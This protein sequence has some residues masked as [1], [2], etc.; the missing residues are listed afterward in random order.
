MRRHLQ[1]RIG[2][3]FGRTRH[4]KNRYCQPGEK[5]GILGNDPKVPEESRKVVRLLRDSTFIGQV[6]KSVLR[7][8]K[9]DDEGVYRRHP[10]IESDDG[11]GEDGVEGD[12][13][14]DSGLMF[15]VDD[16]GR[17]RTSF[18]PVETGR[19]SSSRPA[20]QNLCCDDRTEF[21]TRRGWVGGPDL[22]DD[23]IT[24][25]Y[26]PETGAIDFVKPDAIVRQPYRGDMIHITTENHGSFPT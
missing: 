2:C 10:V 25:Q 5:L 17:V 16:D 21:L 4:R 26:W 18:Y 22:R 11:F 1:R 24:A 13:V 19:C 15:Y 9:T 7:P 23:D 3:G 8:A 14:Y 12:L 6:L 20:L